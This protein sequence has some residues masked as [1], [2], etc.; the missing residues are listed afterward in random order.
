MHA[1]TIRTKGQRIVYAVI[2]N[3]IHC[4]ITQAVTD[5]QPLKRLNWP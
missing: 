1:M 5:E 4:S 2:N 3:N